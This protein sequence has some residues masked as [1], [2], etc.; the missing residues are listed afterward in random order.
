MAS[1]HA[2]IMGQ[3]TTGDRLTMTGFARSYGWLVLA[4]CIAGVTAVV[5]AP[6][7]RADARADARPCPKPSNGKKVGSQ[8]PPAPKRP[9][10]TKHACPSTGEASSGI[11]GARLASATSV[12]VASVPILIRVPL[13]RTGLTMSADHPAPSPAIASTPAPVPSA[14]P[15]PDLQVTA[16]PRAGVDDSVVLVGVVLAFLLAVSGVVLGAGRR[17]GRHHAG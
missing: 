2:N 10:T 8:H 1:T 7:A 9:S 4:L 16:S 15:S 13:A 14:A 6:G 17:S 12:E 11:K 5:L 3:R